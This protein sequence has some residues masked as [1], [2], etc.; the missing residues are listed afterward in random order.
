MIQVSEYPPHAQW[1]CVPRGEPE[2]VNSKHG[3]DCIIIV[4]VFISTSEYP[5]TQLVAV[6]A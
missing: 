2:T 3:G 6:S 5:A 4:I 1:Q